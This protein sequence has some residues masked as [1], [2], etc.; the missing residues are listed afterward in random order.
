MNDVAFSKCRQI[1]PLPRRTVSRRMKYVVTGGAGFIGSHIAEKLAGRGDEV[2]IID[3]LSAGREI[4][5][6][7]MIPGY[8]IQLEPIEQ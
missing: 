7:L 8:R 2:V 4:D 1:F 3:D 6:R 5:D